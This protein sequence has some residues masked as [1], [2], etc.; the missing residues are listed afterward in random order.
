MKNA[1]ISPNESVSYISG[2]TDSPKP[3][4]IYT[5][6]PNAERVAEVSTT[7]FEVASPLFWIACADDVIADQFYYD[8]LTQTI[9]ATPEPTPHPT[10]TQPV[11]TGAQTIGTQT[12]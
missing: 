7:Q 11:S 12:L 1:L 3:Q 4:P 2:W 10:L 9:I 6:I 5:T 8:S